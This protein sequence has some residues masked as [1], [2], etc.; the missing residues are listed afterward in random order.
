MTTVKF[1]Q[2]YYVAFSTASFPLNSSGCNKGSL[3]DVSFR[4]EGRLHPKIMFFRIAFEDPASYEKN[5]KHE[6]TI[7]SHEKCEAVTFT[8][9]IS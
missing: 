8:G 3:E 7:T 1:I 5:E 4:H 6:G 9:R 2:A